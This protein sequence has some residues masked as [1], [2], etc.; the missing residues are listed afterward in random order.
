MLKSLKK[1][2]LAAVGLIYLVILLKTSLMGAVGPIL[3]PSPKTVELV[4][5]ISSKLKDLIF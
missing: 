4:I 5:Y 2:T 1:V 3:K